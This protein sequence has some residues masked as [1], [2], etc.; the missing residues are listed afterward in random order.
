M[1][2]T[3]HNNRP[4][5]EGWKNLSS[6][7]NNKPGEKLS[8][9]FGHDHVKTKKDAEGNTLY[10]LMD[11]DEIAKLLNDKNTFCVVPGEELTDRAGHNPVHMSAINTAE[12]IGVKRK[13][14]VLET[15]K[16]DAA[17]VVAHAK[18]HKRPVFRARPLPNP[19][20]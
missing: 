1:V 11:Y 18:A 14:T 5:K 16:A 6:H 20:R 12:T 3:D 19:H 10:R 17:R 13:A 8:E 2:L 7:K 9:E 15:A 4:S